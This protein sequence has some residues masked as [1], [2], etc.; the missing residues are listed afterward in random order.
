[1]H[2]R[3]HTHAG[4]LGVALFSH[5]CTVPTG[6][7]SAAGGEHSLYAP[8]GTVPDRC[9]LVAPGR[10]LFAN[11]NFQHLGFGVCMRSNM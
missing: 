4:I 7:G 11:A 1:M 2:T 10:Y 3:T 8:K 6:E 9:D 5:M